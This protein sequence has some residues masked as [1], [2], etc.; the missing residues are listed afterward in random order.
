MHKAVTRTTAQDERHRPAFV[1]LVSYILKAHLTMPL[2]LRHQVPPT[3][4]PKEHKEQGTNP[5]A[6]FDA[7]KTGRSQLFPFHDMPAWFRHENNRWILHGYRTISQSV[8][9]SICS[10]SYLHNESVNIYSHLIPAVFFLVVQCRTHLHLASKHDDVTC[11]DVVA[12]SIFMVAA[13]ACFLLS[14]L[15]HTLSNHSQRAERCFLRLDMLGVVVFMMGDLILG[16]YLI[17]WCERLPRNI[18]WVTVSWPPLQL[19]LRLLFTDIISPIVRSLHSLVCW[20][21]PRQ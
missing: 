13:A 4:S 3:R 18:Y 2:A 15:Y 16:A 21:S 1:Q 12:F 10:L 5:T 19:P 11:A 6:A 14:A 20:P 8:C 17:F 9:G 7:I